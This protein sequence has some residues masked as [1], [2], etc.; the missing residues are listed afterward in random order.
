M[1]YIAFLQHSDFKRLGKKRIDRPTDPPDFQAKR[2]NKPFI[3]IF[4][5]G[6][7][8]LETFVETSGISPWENIFVSL[9][10]TTAATQQ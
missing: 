3:F 8:A 1:I 10:Q 6:L 4:F 5:F 7:M 9:N 2:A